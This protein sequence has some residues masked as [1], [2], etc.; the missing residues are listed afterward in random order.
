MVL[1]CRHKTSMILV[2][3]F[4]PKF[5]NF[6]AG[7]IS[8][9]HVHSRSPHKCCGL[10]YVCLD[11]D[12]SESPLSPAATVNSIHYDA[13]S[14]ADTPTMNQPAP[15][16]CQACRGINVE[17]LRSTGG[18]RHLSADGMTRTSCRLC[19]VLKESIGLRLWDANQETPF[20]LSIT[21]KRSSMGR[22]EA[23]L[24][25]SLQPAGAGYNTDD[26]DDTDN[27]DDTDVTHETTYT[28]I[29][30]ALGEF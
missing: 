3:G 17:S 22:L 18:Y 30:T 4:L 8:I 7:Q 27:T 25:V 5:W 15:N 13:S 2:R 19:K 1:P 29:T 23:R 24:T 16:L 26:T 20:Y 14:L 10:I 12:R 11:L 21:E 9:S 28:C 6:G